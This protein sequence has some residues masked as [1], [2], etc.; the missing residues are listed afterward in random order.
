MI[1]RSLDD[2]KVSYKH[3]DFSSIISLRNCLKRG[4][5]ISFCPEIS[6]IDQVAHGEI[7]IVNWEP[8]TTSVLMI[9]HVHKWQSP[10]LKHFMELAK[11][12]IKEP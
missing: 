5:G 1:E 2:K 12:E 3:L 11:E 8:V 9:C 6:I 7:D 10:L 4:L